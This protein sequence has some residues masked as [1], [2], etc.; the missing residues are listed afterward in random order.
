MLATEKK[1]GIIFYITKTLLIISIALSLALSAILCYRVFVDPN[2]KIDLNHI[3]L[4][5]ILF[6]TGILGE[7]LSEILKKVIS[8]KLDKYLQSD[9]WKQFV[10]DNIDPIIADNKII[11]E[12]KENIKVTTLEDGSVDE[13]PVVD[14]QPVIKDTVIVPASWSMTGNRNFKIYFCQK[15]RSFGDA[16][17]IALYGDKMIQCIG[18]RR[19][20]TQIELGKKLQDDSALQKWLI[21]EMGITPDVSFLDFYDISSNYKELK[22]AH[23]ASGPLVRKQI[24]SSLEKLNKAKTTKEI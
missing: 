11:K 4:I 19:K 8:T 7:Q 5:G 9:D 18:Q 2:F 24:Y 14:S 6:V 13:N 17:Y 15:D 10:R 23:E 20:L 21:E 22:I 16:K 3:Y 1:N 12:I